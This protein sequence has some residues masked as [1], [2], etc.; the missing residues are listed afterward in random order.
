MKSRTEARE[1]TSSNVSRNQ[2]KLKRI[3]GITIHTRGLP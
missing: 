2:E 3:W 1:C